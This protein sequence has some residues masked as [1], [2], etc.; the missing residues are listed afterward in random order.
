MPEEIIPTEVPVED[1]S[2]Q[3]EH[4]EKGIAN[5]RTLLAAATENAD[6]LRWALHNH[7]DKEN[8]SARIINGVIV[9]GKA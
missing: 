8:L 4:A 1:L 5:L 3:L 6:R 2:T 9:K 7:V